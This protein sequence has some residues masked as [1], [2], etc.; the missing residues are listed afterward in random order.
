MRSNKHEFSPSVVEMLL[1]GTESPRYPQHSPRSGVQGQFWEENGSNIH[2]DVV[3]GS[4][5]L[6]IYRVRSGSTLSTVLSHGCL[7][8]II[9]RASTS[10]SFL[11]RNLMVPIVICMN[12]PLEMLCF[13]WTDDRNISCCCLS[14][15]WRWSGQIGAWTTPPNS[16]PPSSYSS[17]PWTPPSKLPRTATISSTTTRRILFPLRIFPAI[18]ITNKIQRRKL[19]FQCNLCWLLLVFCLDGF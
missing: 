13:Y 7:S 8:P 3:A 5:F 9:F 11:E 18:M 16:P 6:W 15:D 2:D 4:S 19:I 12:L 1:P 10:L 17:K 14:K